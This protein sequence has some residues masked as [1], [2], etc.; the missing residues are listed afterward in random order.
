MVYT[1]STATGYHYCAEN[2]TAAVTIDIEKVDKGVARWWAAILAPDQGW[3]AIISQQDDDMY[4]APW[5]VSLDGTPC[6]GIK[7][8]E[9]ELLTR[10]TAVSTPPSSYEAFGLLA[11]FSLLHNLGSQFSAAL[12]TALIL[13]THNYYGTVAQLPYPTQIGGFGGHTPAQ[14]VEMGWAAIN[15]E[16]PYYMAL[17][18]SP[19]IVMSSLCGVFWNADFSCNLVSPWLH[20][21]IREVP[22]GDGIIDIPGRYHEILAFV[23]ALRRPP[24]S[25]LWLGAAISGLVPSILKFVE[26]GTPHLDHNAFP[27][28]GCPQSFMDVTDS[29]P[30][31]SRNS[32]SEGI[33]I[34]RADV[35]QIRYLPPVFDDDLHYEHRP[36]A[37]WKPVGR[38]N[39]QSCDL[40]VQVHH[41]C[42]RHY[43]SYYC[44]N[45]KL[46]NGLIIEDKGFRMA[47]TQG[48]LPNYNLNIEL[49]T[50]TVFPTV[51][52]P[53]DQT[54][55]QNA[56]RT[57]LQ[58]ATVNGEGVPAE[59]IYHDKWVQDFL[60]DDDDSDKDGHDDSDDDNDDHNDSPS[61]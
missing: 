5:W 59:G 34:A 38:S 58:R 7:W 57:I 52:L 35:W 37:P 31:F 55:S 32:S 19:S 14:Q 40:R 15:K 3:K 18:C 8:P 27:W 21:I 39:I 25:A 46:S 42:Q 48:V 47:A 29:G 45:W 44:W 12:A 20:P 1:D 60:Q 26:S 53:L 51:P 6:V 30:Y 54:A 13:P 61:T 23:C 2:N 43:L 4:Q 28:T 16:L 11:K 50:S 33:D 22:K 24:L 56:S 10:S 41:D 9:S 36:F 17:S 49:L